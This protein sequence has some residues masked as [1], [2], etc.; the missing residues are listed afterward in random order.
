MKTVTDLVAAANAML[1]ASG[2]NLAAQ[3]V[4]FQKA[5]AGLLKAVDDAT[6]E[7]AWATHAERI[8]AVEVYATDEVEIDD[9]AMVSRADEG[10][11]VAAWVWLDNE[12]G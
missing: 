10:L 2:N 9:K 5:Y 4:P 8:R 11:W 1:K 12:P 7:N 6:G 3:P